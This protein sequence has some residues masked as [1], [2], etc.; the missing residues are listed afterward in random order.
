MTNGYIKIRRINDITGK[1][2]IEMLICRDGHDDMLVTA[3][4][5]VATPITEAITAR[6]T[7]EYRECRF[8]CDIEIIDTKGE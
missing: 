7:Y 1:S 5:N 6:S 4:G 2:I 3:E 8:D